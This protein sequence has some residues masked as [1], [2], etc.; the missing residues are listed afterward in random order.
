MENV[1]SILEWGEGLAVTEWDWKDPRVQRLRDLCN[2][3]T[4]QTN[5]VYWF[6]KELYEKDGRVELVV[7]NLVA[8]YAHNEGLP[9]REAMQKVLDLCREY[10]REFELISR[11]VDMDD[12]ICDD[13]KVFIRGIKCMIPD[14]I[15]MSLVL[16]RF[17]D[18]SLLRK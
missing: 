12:G 11:D 13:T 6:E 4:T 7:S 9:V 8:Y 18:Q 16:P 5:D 2:K 17:N 3:S 15:H 10:E 14:N 1:Y